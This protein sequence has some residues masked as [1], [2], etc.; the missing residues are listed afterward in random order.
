MNK[1]LALK[2]MVLALFLL[3]SAPVPGQTFTTNDSWVFRSDVAAGQNMWGPGTS[4]V[5]HKY[6]DH[7]GI[8]SG[9][10]KGTGIAYDLQADTGTV[11]GNVE[12]QIKA[13]YDNH[14]T[15]PGK[16]KI[17]LS[18][19]G[20]PDESKIST[21]FGATLGAT[22]HFKVDLPWWVNALPPLFVPDIDISLP[23]NML[24]ASIN[25]DK[26]FT[27]GLNQTT[28]TVE[29]M[30]PLALG[31][32][33]VLANFA[34][35]LGIKQSLSFKPET[36]KGTM[37]YT[38]LETQTERTMDIVFPGE[39]EAQLLDLEVDLD[40]PGHWEFSLEN[41]MI[42]DNVFSQ[43][44]DLFMALVLGIPILTFEAKYETTLFDFFDLFQSQEFK[45]DFLAHG[46]D[47]DDTTIDRLGRFHVHVDSV[48]VP[49]A[50]WLL[51][52]G[53]LALVGMR[54]KPC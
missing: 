22:P 7:F 12:G 28:S 38:H 10:L 37:K 16:T 52:S 23:I 51:G 30:E 43:D 35:E 32:D 14:L 29:H 5:N 3:L 6:E 42:G 40:L 27:T 19:N 53:L 4:P 21:N 2:Q 46:F 50:I 33:L 15:T 36:I 45:L 34:L 13:Q 54:R 20:I 31:F 41:F 17:Q 24:N 8:D 44:L 9:M 11:S 47:G 49:G 39:G 18:Y 48:P 26:D 25:L 1:N